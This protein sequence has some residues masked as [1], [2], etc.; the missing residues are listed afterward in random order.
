MCSRCKGCPYRDGPAA[1]TAEYVAPRFEDPTS[2]LEGFT[3]AKIR[4]SIAA[5]ET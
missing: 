2:T 4:A 5:R 3:D 1:C